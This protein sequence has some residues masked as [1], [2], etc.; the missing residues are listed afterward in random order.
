MNKDSYHHG[1]LKA[2]LIQNGLKILD[3]EGYEGF[4]LRKV[5]K[6]C[7]VTQ[8]AAYRHFADKDSLVTA[9]ALE[10]E[11]RFDQT[12]KEAGQKYEE[13]PVKRLYEIGCAYI[14]FFIK[15]PAYLRLVFFNGLARKL[16]I[17]A[18]KQSDET[19][20]G[21]TL[22]KPFQTFYTAV[23]RYQAVSKKYDALSL[24]ELVLYL[25]GLVHGI[26]MLV[27]RNHLD[28]PGDPMTLV[29]NLIWKG[30]IL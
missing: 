26:A 8:T 2:E 25:W 4:S 3:E 5:A 9:I 27:C 7:N 15:N 11:Q 12:L 21:T 29:R 10:V 22:S 17:Q 14:G 20:Q 19:F 6:A 13:D 1:N 30:N 28:L 23:E 24:Q 18:E 16:R